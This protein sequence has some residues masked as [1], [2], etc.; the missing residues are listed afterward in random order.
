MFNTVATWGRHHQL[1]PEIPKGCGSLPV[2]GEVSCC[3]MSL[4]WSALAFGDSCC[5]FKIHCCCNLKQF[6]N[7][8]NV[9]CPVIKRERGHQGGRTHLRVSSSGVKYQWVSCVMTLARAEGPEVWGWPLQNFGGHA[10]RPESRNHGRQWL[11]ILCPEGTAPLP[12]VFM[13][14]GSQASSQEFWVSESP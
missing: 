12:T 2:S 5:Y 9:I 8:L 13:L 1:K 14:M 10:E 3:Y 6:K 11:W 4:N 7:L